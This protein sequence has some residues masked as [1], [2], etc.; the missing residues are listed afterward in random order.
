MKNANVGMGED[1]FAKGIIEGIS[2]HPS[3][4]CKDKVGGGTVPI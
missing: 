2:I 3:A 4:G 1:E